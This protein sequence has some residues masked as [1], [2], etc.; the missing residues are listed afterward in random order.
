[1]ISFIVP[2]HNYGFMLKRCINSILSNEKKYVRE[3][4]IIND[5]SKDNTD[6]IVKKIK[7]NKKIKYFKK[8]YR[9]LS[10]T[11]NFGISQAE[12]NLICKVDADDTI[13]KK[14]A[15]NNYLFMKK[16]KADFVFSNV[17]VNDLVKKKKYFKNQNSKKIFRFFSY[18]HGSGCLFKKKIWKKVGKFNQNN[19]YQDDFDFWLKINKL[20]NIKIRHLNKALYIYNKHNKNMSKS[21]FLK[22]LTKLKILIKNLIL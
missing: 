3:I 2:T 17:L 22:N 10:K 11:T 12:G 8:N 7:K 4:L 5:A 19:F 18:P 16:T 15:E 9:N 20:Q 13:N 21:F 6:Q 1:M 14:F